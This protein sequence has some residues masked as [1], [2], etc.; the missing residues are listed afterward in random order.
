MKKLLFFAIFAT[1]VLI[2]FPQLTV[3]NGF[4]AA[5]LGNNLAGSNISVTNAQ[6]SGSNLQVG[7]FQFAGSGFPLSSGIVLS[8]GS[9]FDCPGPNTAPGSGADLGGAGNPLLDAISG[10]STNDAVMLQFD[11]TVQSDKIEFNYIFASE[12]YNEFVGSYNDVFAFF[13]SGPGISGEENIAVVPGT[14][15]PVTINN[16]NLDNYWQ[17]YNNNESG[18]TN[19]QFD[20]FTTI[21][22]AKK[23]GLV[24][25]KTYR[26]KLIIADAGDGAYDS[27]VF[28]QEGSLVQKNISVASHTYNANNTALE[29]CI[30]ASFT[31]NLDTPRTTDTYIEY[32]ISGSAVNGT[33]YEHID[34]IV[35]ISAGQ[36]SATI[37]IDAITD[38][39]TEGTESVKLIYEPEPCL[40]YDTISMY[41]QDYQMLQFDAAPV[42][43]SCF[44]SAD[45]QINFNITGGTPPFTI[46]LQDSATGITTTYGSSPITG[47]SAGVYKIQVLDSYGCSDLDI[48]AN[49]FHTSVTIQQPSVPAVTETVVSPS[50]G[51]NN[52]SI[53]LTA[54]GGTPPF[55]FLWSNG[56]TTQNLSGVAAGTHVVTITDN[57]GCQLV[58]TI[59]LP[60]S[61]APVVQ[62]VVTHESCSGMDNGS[63]LLT[64]SGGTPPF[65]FLW[66]S[67]QT[68]EDI[69]MLV[70]GNY[71]VQVTDFAGCINASG[72][73][74]LAASPV[75]ISGTVTNETCG[76]FNGV[77]D[78]SMN[79]GLSPYSFLWSNGV[80][81]QDN[82]GLQQG[83]YTLTATDANACTSTASYT[84]L[85]I[86]GNCIP[87]CDLAIQNT[88]VTDETCG[89]GNGS[90]SINIFSTHLPYTV[91]W[92]N[93]ATSEGLSGISEGSYHVT[94]SDAENCTAHQSFTVGNLAGTLGVNATVNAETCGNS[95][96]SVNITPS[97]GVQPYYYNWS[98]GATT[99]DVSG[100]HAGIFNLSLTDANSCE[101]HESYTVTNNSG[102]L[103][104]IYGNAMNADCNQAN[105][106]VDISVSG[107]Y[108]WINY[109]WSNGATSQDITGLL[110]GNYTCTVTDGDGCTLITPV[111]TVGNNSGT[112]AFTYINAKNE[113][114]GNLSGEVKILVN[115]G[116]QPYTYSW[117]NGAA[118]QNIYNLQAGTYSC[119]I[120]DNSG[121]SITTG[122]ITLINAPG[123]L[124]LNNVSVINETCSNGLG[125]VQLNISGGTLPVSFYWNTGSVSQNITN[126]HAGTYSC[127]VTDSAGC[128]FAVN[129]TVLNEQGTLH[130]ENFVVTDETCG[131]GAGSIN[132]VISGGNG[133]T[134][135]AWSSGQVTED[136]GSLHSGTYSV[137]IN[138]S[139]G[140]HTTGSTQVNNL[141]GNLQLAIQSVSNEVCNA[142]NGA[143]NIAVSGGSSPYVYS[144]TNGAVTEDINNLQAGNYSCSI[145]DASGCI[146]ST[147]NIAISNSAGLL[148]ISSFTVTDE[149]CGNQGGA[150]NISVTGGTGQ[151]TCLWS[152]GAVTQD[153][154][155]LS[156]GSYQVTVTDAG[157][158][159]VTGD[160]IVENSSGTLQY[161]NILT[162]DETCGNHNGSIN[163]TVTGGALPYTF[164]WSNGATTQNLSGISSGVYSLI[165]SDANG[166]ATQTGQIT[167][168]DNPGNFAVVSINETAATCANSNGSVNVTL[169]GGTPPFYYTWSNGAVTRDLT[170]L[171]AGVYSC[172]A[173][174]SSGCVLNYSA[175]VQ[176]NAGN[177]AVYSNLTQPTCGQSNGAINITVVGGATPYTYL[178][179]NGA[180]TQD[181]TG[182]SNGNYTVNIEDHNGCNINK[183]YSII[184]SGAVVISAVNV[185]DENCGN[186]QG[187]IEVIVS[188]GTQPYQFDW[189]AANPMPCCNYTLR[190]YDSWGDGW[191]GA[192]LAVS[193][194]G[195]F[196]GNYSA[197]ADTAIQNIPVC[198][199]DIITLDYS[200]GTYENEV[201]YTLVNPSG[202]TVFS[203]GPFPLTGL[204][205]TGTAS[206]TFDPP[207][208]NTL[209]GLNAGDYTADI[210][211]AI[212]CSA[213]ASATVVNNTGNFEISANTVTNDYCNSGAG[214]INITVTGGNPPYQYSWSNGSATQDISGLTGGAYS[215]DISD[216]S[217]CT[218]SGVYNVQNVTGT[219]G[220]DPAVVTNVYCGNSAGAVNITA[221][222]TET[223]FTYS[224]SNGA[225]TEDIS[226]VPSGAYIVTVTDASGCAIN[227]TFDIINQTNGLNLTFSTVQPVCNNSNGSINMAVSGGY[228]PYLFHWGNG[229][230][231]EDLSGLNQGNYS[232]TVTD[233]AACQATE[234][235]SLNGTMT[236][237]I[238]SMNVTDEYC[239]NSNG[240]INVTA[241]GGVPPYT[242]QWGL[243][244]STPCCSYGLYLYDG[245]GNGW[246]GSY[247]DV[248]VNNVPYGTY[249]LQSGSSYYISIPVCTDDMLKLNY[250]G[251]YMDNENYVYLL[252]ADGNTIFYAGPTPANGTI[253]NSAST[254]GINLPNTSSIYNLGAND[255]V[256]TITDANGC[257]VSDTATV[258]NNTNGFV[259][260]SV[261]ATD[262][263]CSNGTGAIDINVNGGILPYQYYWSNGASTQDLDN[264]S[265]GTYSVS[266]YDGN[267]CL[268]QNTTT[269]LN[270]PGTLAFGPVTITDTYCG[271]LSGAIDVTI[272]GD[273]TPFVITWSNGSVTED[274]TDIP[275]GIYQLTVTDAGNCTIQDTFTVVNNTTNGLALTSA[276]T[277]AFCGNNQ[278]TINLTISGGITPF[279]I[280]W[281][282]GAT[283]E[284]LTNIAGGIYTASVTDATGCTAIE[285][286]TV[287]DTGSISVTSD[288]IDEICNNSQGE[289]TITA[290]GGTLPYTYEW[291]QPVEPPCCSYSLRMYD[292]FGDGWNGGFLEVFV[293]GSSAGTFSA[294]G[295]SSVSS[296]NICTGYQVQLTY[297]PGTWEEENTYELVNSAGT[298]IFS[299][300]PYPDTGAVFSATASCT[301]NP[302]GTNHLTGLTNG[303]Y[304]LLVT[305]ANGCSFSDSYT[306]AN[307]TGNFVLS[308]VSVTDD[309]CGNNTGAID[310]TVSGG[311]T[312]YTFSWSNGAATEDISNIP[313]GNYIISIHDNNGCKLIDSGMVSNQA[314]TLQISNFNVTGT[315]CGNN[316]GAI[317]ITVTGGTAP[318]AYLWSNGSTSGDL[319][320]IPSGTYTLTVT[321]NTG[322]HITGSFSVVNQTNGLAVSYT[323]D[324]ETCNNNSGSI[325]LTVSGGA[326]PYFTIWSNSDT[327]QDLTNLIAGIY[328]FTVTDNSGCSQSGSVTI[329]NLQGDLFI[330]TDDIQ[331]DYCG[332]GYGAINISVQGGLPPFSYW[333]SNGS[334]FQDI[335]NAVAGNYTLTVTD[336][337][338]C[339][340]IDYFEIPYSALAT[341]TDTVIQS[342]SCYTCSDGSIDITVNTGT[343]VTYLW[344]N[345]A[346]TEDIYNL[347]Q[348]SYSVTITDSY[349]CTL[350]DAFTVT[351]PL[352]SENAD[353]FSESFEVYPNP[354]KGLVT[355][356]FK[357]KES[358]EI[359]I[360]V[361]NM[362]GESIYNSEKQNVKSGTLKIDL[363]GV[364]DGIYIFSIKTGNHV[365]TKRISIIQQ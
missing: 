212:G 277:D 357:I 143:I 50:C 178:W 14:T 193:V 295:S 90:I 180:V 104:L 304:N 63:I 206:C 96:G 146:I 58:K 27:G 182:L 263:N 271:S 16:I 17:F 93:G 347:T 268:L 184:S 13:I 305:E 192:F 179:S 213:T 24:P 306:V 275:S 40:G 344:S 23:E 279:S 71:N 9:I 261:T 308:N 218:V 316:A 245:N 248:L 139:Q 53:S 211:D 44:E 49:P 60:N 20:G 34:P 224:W 225:T 83:A 69:T 151:V 66:S 318:Y 329:Q 89:N 113:T 78:I 289:I 345:S 6:V 259:I 342:T 243:A 76:N 256:V 145:T 52:G 166:C 210:T 188:G 64:V 8:S 242:Y 269:I 75:T 12:E 346:T 169:S 124:A 170:A 236:V 165:L 229:A 360:S 56:D 361:N 132:L 153:I 11:F 262:D 62:A 174:D 300:G 362:L 7:T 158:C 129:A 91:S 336:N 222:G 241:S 106:S 133:A 352:G 183:S 115:G 364:K 334:T 81:T 171:L 356:S 70:P 82:S 84:I 160:Y 258:A 30:N 194:N 234:T 28:L 313:A 112:L 85:N 235:I 197:F 198:T 227:D 323:S 343:S 173:T 31:F 217:G 309:N 152:N 301:F 79:G 280:N 125:S 149:V 156:A 246:N 252:D 326:A 338:G 51:L 330:I 141:A 126:V 239:G 29:G 292:N 120:T 74:I 349:G 312:P 61:S 273:Q 25:C 3:Q 159:S 92:S 341:I 19:I 201:S 80:T 144:W 321:D 291:S 57:S 333:W 288:I 216:F 302:S 272:S 95:N 257:S 43:L 59:S 127:Q 55:T 247:V 101:V 253:Y 87:D 228:P 207:D 276:T 353:G 281:S 10:M 311:V 134:T 102:S 203:D 284:D 327:S 73:E 103:Q 42:N 331:T 270:N 109:N 131:N 108:Y 209:T 363:S 138:D 348:G 287:I 167:V 88:V 154:S 41:I 2:A 196:V 142:M 264:L 130:I 36:T 119:T 140:C 175:T 350:T 358:S 161:S 65:S 355:V 283:S 266:I 215:V 67:G 157:N 105:G 244:D 359:L 72:Y 298:V 226:G 221:H 299:N 37:M 117:S 121:C 111:Y 39:I 351:Y 230:V 265:Q 118:T 86:A 26:L 189:S 254:C 205:Y 176:S 136:I 303:V 214:A 267:Y 195:S 223:P 219:L 294:S 22:T 335:S 162:S 285:T 187:A 1:H 324:N 290:S 15:S 191:N 45:G 250:T 48:D 320:T 202:V 177:L 354:S 310:I 240:S 181:L 365:I 155:G 54:T 233:N 99:Q 249:T 315:Y 282:N 122:A 137:S 94:V 147:G 114:C 322:C 293:N 5:Q 185:T 107:S 46:T 128:S 232:V 186:S 260:S 208:S 97:G 319:D 204:V 68:S 190:M 123:T 172:T 274:L 238:N 4:N 38:A 21:L 307:A 314:G 332:W 32:F 168:S 328:T 296:F 286:N 340:D 98:T 278:G 220:F 297:T 325:D 251:G 77:V 237:T 164:T 110:P 35:V 339:S 150:V 199:G 135:C 317:D 116:M 33:D 148:S 47:L 231:T 163:L 18:N 255:Y 337:N 100:L 200:S